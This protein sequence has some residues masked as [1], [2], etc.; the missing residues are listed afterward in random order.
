MLNLI[1]FCSY[2]LSQFVLYIVYEFPPKMYHFDLKITVQ[3]SFWVSLLFISYNKFELFKTLQTCFK[4]PILL[5]INFWQCSTSLQHKQYR[6]HAHIFTFTYKWHPYLINDSILSLTPLSL[7]RNFKSQQTGQPQPTLH[8]HP[9]HW[10]W[11]MIAIVQWMQW[12]HNM[13]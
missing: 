4:I 6:C 1:V 12:S 7:N 8:S 9:I 10:C 3:P 5:H 13:G 2:F 11:N